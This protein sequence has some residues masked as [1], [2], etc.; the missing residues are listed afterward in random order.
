MGEALK[1]FLWT[2][3]FHF[4]SDFQIESHNVAQTGLRHVSFSNLDL[5]LL[6]HRDYDYTI[7]CFTLIL[8]ITVTNVGISSPHLQNISVSKWPR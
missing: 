7:P 8:N 4:Y 6:S 1:S 3:L 2:R 5:S